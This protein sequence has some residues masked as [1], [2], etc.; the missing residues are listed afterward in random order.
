MNPYG[1]QAGQIWADCDVRT[2]RT[3]TVLEVGAHQAVVLSSKGR[4]TRIRLS[5]FRPGSTGY[6][7]IG[8]EHD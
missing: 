6:R 3:M 7:L 4:K 8:Y 2:P 5:R 1:V